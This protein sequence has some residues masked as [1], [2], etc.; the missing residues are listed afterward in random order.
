MRRISNTSVP[1]TGKTTW[2]KV[3]FLGAEGL[4][5]SGNSQRPRTG[6]ARGEKTRI[7]KLNKR[8]RPNGETQGSEPKRGSTLKRLSE[9]KRQ[10]PRRQKSRH[11]PETSKGGKKSRGENQARRQAPKAVKIHLGGGKG[12]HI[13][14]RSLFRSEKKCS[15]RKAN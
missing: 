2:R 5:E 12:G 7:R 3:V 6:G 10:K 15:A 14:G 1:S 4:K 13:A 11:R 9:K 8:K